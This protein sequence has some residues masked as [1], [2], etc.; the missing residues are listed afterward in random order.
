MDDLITYTCKYCN[1]ICKNKNSLA[2][3]EIRCKFN[4]NRLESAFVKFNKERD[5]V[6]NKGLTKETIFQ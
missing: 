4:P 5:K 6:W 1:K 3:H 2:Q